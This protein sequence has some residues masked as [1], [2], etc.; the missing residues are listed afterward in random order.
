M[1][2]RGLRRQPGG[3]VFRRRLRLLCRGLDHGIDGIGIGQQQCR[4]QEGA[5]VIG[6]N[7]R[8]LRRQLA[9]DLLG[10]AVH[11]QCCGRL[12]QPGLV[13]I[14]QGIA[15]FRQTVN[16][17]LQ[18]CHQ[19]TE[20]RDQRLFGL[21]RLQ[22]LGNGRRC[23]GQRG[24]IANR[25]RLR[26]S[27]QTLDQGLAGTGHGGDFRHLGHGEGATHGVHG[28]QQGFVHRLRFQLA[29]G[30]PATQG[31]QVGGDFGLQDIQQDTVHRGRRSGLDRGLLPAGSLRLRLCFRPCFRLWRTG[32]G[33]G[34]TACRGRDV[35]DF[36]AGG[37]ALG[38]PLDG[39]QVGVHRAAVMQGGVQL[40]QDLVHRQGHH[41]HNR[42]AGRTQAVTHAV[43]HAFNG[44]AE[45]A[46]GA[47][48]DQ[49][50]TALEGMEHPAYRQQL[51]GQPR[52]GRPGRQHLLQVGQF[53]VEL[54]QEDFADFQ[55]I[56]I[57]Q[58][59]R[60]LE[61]GLV[62][63][64][65][66]G[67]GCVSRNGGGHPAARQGQR[68][69]IE[70]GQEGRFF[71]TPFQRLRGDQG[72]AFG[73]HRV[74]CR[75]L[76]CCRQTGRAQLIFHR[77]ATPAVIGLCR[78]HREVGVV[79]QQQ[80]RVQRQ[81]SLLIDRLLIG[82]LGQ[83]GVKGSGVQRPGRQRRQRI[84]G[85]LQFR[86]H[87]HR[88]LQHRGF[89]FGHD[90]IERTARRFRP[91]MRGGKHVRVVVSGRQLR[92]QPGSRRHL[93]FHRFHRFDRIN[94]FNSTVGGH[95][96]QRRDGIAG[97]GLD[98]G[99][100]HVRRRHCSGFVLDRRQRP[101]TQGLQ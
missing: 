55:R 32:R 86:R 62:V 95:P 39:Q 52:V 17:L 81:D 31:R 96:G 71:G 69:G 11:R 42:R 65:R 46:Q 38:N 89:I 1:H 56:G 9:G 22:G 64:H 80:C 51:R 8:G 60:V 4:V 97:V 41:G 54:F 48:T 101:V 14:D 35:I 98:R 2:Q 77:Q 84:G 99:N 28:T 57:H 45:L 68:A 6:H 90:R 47:C 36:L 13:G 12:V 70:F 40:R 29:G 50:A 18:L 61:A 94:R 75:N 82:Q 73:Q 53:L 5:E 33:I 26:G 93:R 10:Q 67:I 3:F 72:G 49:A 7:G 66:H 58:A 43:E 63:R 37:D 85:R 44:P 16:L 100:S 74:Q 19:I 88:G 15:R 24:N 25:R 30:Q 27:Q 34:S 78:R 87:H 20:M 23:A 91:L 92:G 21:Q 83:Q 76:P 79:N 59:A